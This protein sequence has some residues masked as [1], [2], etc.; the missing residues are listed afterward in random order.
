VNL[1]EIQPVLLT[2]AVAALGTA[3][4]LLAVVITNRTQIR[5]QRDNNQFQIEI[6]R[7]KLNGELTSKQIET[8]LL[9]IGDAHKILN[10]IEREFSINEIVMMRT[11]AL[12]RAAFNDKYR[13]LS[14]RADE[15]GMIVDF[16]APSASKTCREIDGHMNIFWGNFSNVL[17][18]T[19]RGDEINHADPCFQKAHEAAA[20]I[21]KKV[22]FAKSTLQRAFRASLPES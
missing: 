16:Y 21:A 15:L 19:E 3:S 4:T 14:E 9:K 13:A 5:N 10:Q 20:E 22:E 7:F 2:A 8:A 17:Y 12:S 6:A 11:A 1:I 18:Q